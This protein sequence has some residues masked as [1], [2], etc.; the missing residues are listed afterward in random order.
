MEWKCKAWCNVQVTQIC[1]EVRQLSKLNQLHFI[2]GHKCTHSQL[3]VFQYLNTGA[4]PDLAVFVSPSYLII[5]FVYTNHHGPFLLQM[6]KKKK[7]LY[8]LHIIIQ[9][10]ISAHVFVKV[11]DWRIHLHVVMEGANGAP[12]GS[13]HKHE[14]SI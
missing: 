11:T 13:T 1:T 3:T 9:L 5:N 14:Q 10:Q 12:G 6:E 7:N 4:H 8:L 2:T